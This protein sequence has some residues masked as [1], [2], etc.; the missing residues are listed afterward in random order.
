[1]A[2]LKT[3]TAEQDTTARISI[4]VTGMT[5]AACATR[6]QRKLERA[7]G[8]RAAT[9]NFGTERATVEYAPDADA[10]TLV[11]AVRAAGY[12]ARTETVV[13]D[14]A[15][16]EWAASADPVE[17]ELSRV[18]GVVAASANLSTR[19]ARVEVLADTVTPEALANAVERA[20]YR[21]AE[22][23]EIADPV[24]RERVA[25]TREYHSLLGRFAVAA[26]GA[27]L[28]MLLSMPLMMRESA[29]GGAQL[30]NRLLMPAGDV[31]MRA[32]PALMHTDPGLLRWVLLAITT[33]V[34]FWSGRHFFRGAYSGLLH[35]TT[36][37]NTLIAVGTGSAYAY[38]VVATVWPGLFTRAGLGADVYYEAVTAIIALILLGKV[39]EA[40]AKGRT[41]QAIRSLMGLQPR[42][43][44]VLRAGVE[45][46]VAVTE[47]QA[48][49]EIVVRPGE[50]VPAD[51]VVIHGRSR[52]DESMLTGE[53]MPV[54]KQIGDEVVGGTVNGSG[55]LHFRAER[56]GRDTALAQIVRLVEDAQGNRAPIQRLA[57]RIAAVFVPIVLVIAAAAFIGWYLFGPEPSFLYALIS[58]VTVLI[59]ACP[60]AMGL[61]TPTAVM[62]GT[63]AGAERGVL[64]RGGDRLEAARDIGVV[65][66]DK[67]GTVTEGKPR[68]TGIIG[69][70]DREEELL[71]L[72]ASL[73]RES[74][75]PLGAAILQEARARGLSIAS[76]SDFRVL[77]G[78]GVSGT[79][80]GRRLLLG[81]R[82]LMVE[83]GLDA[84]P[85]DEQA[86]SAA[87]QARTPVYLA[88]D[89]Q[90]V[91]LLLIEDPVKAT[92]AAAISALRD[93]GL[94]VYLLTGDDERTARAVA[95]QVGIDN[96]IAQV[97]PAE[98]AQVIR[99]L[100]TVTG[101]RVAM[102][103]DG[104]NDAPA[105]AQADVGIAIGTGTDVA[106]EASDITLVG[107]D[108]QGV[109]TAMRVSRATMR[110]IR[111]NLFWAF[112]YN[113]LGIPIAAGLLYPF[114]GVLLSPVVASAAMAFSSV[115]VVANSLRLRALI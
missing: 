82:A 114:F 84:Q 55:A 45:Q 19:Q 104:I 24:E 39:L 70:G 28:T 95:R 107:G 61:A 113:V 52:I 100:Q 17:R 76:A 48:G 53:P 27:V 59:I 108:L 34:L 51:G 20:G 36:D 60:C 58:F 69:R 31:F 8:V 25:R 65:V 44:R 54:E 2:D 111:Q 56:V 9:V 86:A 13:L 30:L 1:M 50:R 12:D 78:R 3:A 47:L 64:F 5:C 85:F 80:S 7:P 112:F 66:L 4:P 106:L 73:E 21:L 63:G 105:L 94:E 37:M 49:D 72:A 42:T 14:I 22:A 89:D 23:I 87:A 99:R 29:A 38:S 88:V 91:A 57:D 71:A 43:A 74:E 93:H 97:L 11:A 103:G 109:V 18:P 6:V 41:S 101:R 79:V 83:G 62:V 46:D 110:V 68:V 81:N 67:T 75:H 16:L 15:G 115:S 90:V 33:P 96:V 40:R 92:S 77:S 32:F 98:K 102:V 26:V 10:G 35:G